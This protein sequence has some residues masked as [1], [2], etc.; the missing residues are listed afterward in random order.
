M[1]VYELH[2]LTKIYDGK[3]VLDI[4][5]LKIEE[6]R[7]YSL[8]GP[9]G[10][11]KTT[12]LNILGFLDP[13]SGGNIT[14]RSKP[15]RFV[16]SDLQALR[17]DV[18]LVDQFPILFTAT[19]WK[20]LEF[21]LKVRKISKRK[22]TRMIQEALDLVGM[23]DFAMAQAH[24]LSGG[25]TQ[26]VALARALALSPQVFLCDEPTSSVDVENQAI[27]LNILKR[28]RQT[29]KITIVFT[30]HDHTQAGTI[31]DQTL[32]L[33]R[34]RLIETGYENVFSAVLDLNSPGEIKCV[35]HPKISLLWD[36][37][38]INPAKDRLKVIIDPHQIHPLPKAG[39][40]FPVNVLHGIVRQ[41]MDENSKIRV[42]VDSGVRFTL[43]MTEK[44]Y[45]HNQ[46]LV[47]DTLTYHIPPQAIQAIE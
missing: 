35:I 18:I 36:T 17:R 37:Q 10:A 4:P 32:V 45:R 16:E 24:K 2:Q 31:A 21:G 39:N 14:Y 38:R 20:N 34:G 11:G 44:T 43:L 5:N 12:L 6:H 13:P 47:G 27:I 30:T 15:V 7:I 22:R 8:L 19:V 40:E 1:T 33:D 26:R 28:I 9:N 29:K 46:I 23:R 41:V 25:E 3:T 42:V